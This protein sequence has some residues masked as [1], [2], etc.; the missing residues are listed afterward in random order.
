MEVVGWGNL[1]TRRPGVGTGSPLRAGLHT[2]QVDRVATGLVTTRSL[3]PFL[4]GQRSKEIRACHVDLHGYKGHAP[5]W[6]PPEPLTRNAEQHVFFT[7]SCLMGI[8]RGNSSPAFEDSDWQGIWGV[9]A[10]TGLPAHPAHQNKMNKRTLGR[11]GRGAAWNRT[12]RA[13]KKDLSLGGSGLP[14]GRKDKAERT[15][16]EMCSG[17]PLHSSEKSCLHVMHCSHTWDF[18]FF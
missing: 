2:Q 16:R 12:F 5:G 3:S 7:L 1:R 15:G 18:N 17:K 6:P 8:Q 11:E 4:H 14:E 13:A 9:F 10:P